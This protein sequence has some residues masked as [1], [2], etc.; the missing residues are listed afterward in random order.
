MEISVVGRIEGSDARPVFISAE[1]E[2]DGQTTPLRWGDGVVI[3]TE[4]A[5]VTIKLDREAI[6]SAVVHGR[7]GDVAATPLAQVFADR[8]PGDDVRVRI[9]GVVLAPG[10]VVAASGV[11]LDPAGS[12]VRASY[13]GHGRDAAS[14][15]HARDK[16]RVIATAHAGTASG[17]PAR[18]AAPATARV[19]N[20]WLV[21]L[22]AVAALG[23]LAEAITEP[24]PID[25]PWLRGALLI[26]DAALLAWG[27]RYDTPHAF[28]L[29]V[30]LR[31]SVRRAW[32]AALLLPLAWLGLVRGETTGGLV[33]GRVGT[34]VVACALPVL[35][36]VAYAAA[37]LRAL[38]WLGTAARARPATVA[39]GGDWCRL[40]GVV[41]GAPSRDVIAID[42]RRGASHS[43]GANP[44]Y[45][46]VNRFDVTAEST[47]QVDVAGAVV[48]VTTAHAIVAGVPEW[49]PEDTTT[50]P[51][52]DSMGGDP[53]TRMLWRQYV[54]GDP[55]ASLALAGGDAVTLVG[56]PHQGW[57]ASSGPESLLIVRGTP[58]RALARL[59]TPIVVYAVW[60][61]AVAL[62]VALAP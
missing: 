60:V 4:H 14:A 7:W 28:E 42:V 19:P 43:S 40:A 16:L 15:E 17:Q 56:R 33:D 44:S 29:G 62:A 6:A 58:E 3:A 53:L 50:P 2:I 22:L 39:A 38:R 54:A 52:D 26:A 18:R 5:W 24:S 46:T 34:I 35:A 59:R 41:R 45:F 30:E 13:A 25:S 11:A 31:S 12:V 32:L 61:A 21:W 48:T 49:R 37:N 57:L 20:R 1:L 10:E 36:M 23:M 51:R 9:T 47:F 55:T 8:A 27:T